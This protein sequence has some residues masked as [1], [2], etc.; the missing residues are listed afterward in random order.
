M[1]GDLIGVVLLYAVGLGSENRRRRSLVDCIGGVSV[2][3]EIPLGLWLRI[4]GIR[5]NVR[6]AFRCFDFCWSTFPSLVLWPTFSFSSTDGNSRWPACEIESGRSSPKETNDFVSVA[7]TPSSSTFRPC[8]CQPGIIILPPI[9]LCDSPPASV[10]TAENEQDELLILRFPLVAMLAAFWVLELLI[11]FS[12]LELS[13]LKLLV[14][15]LSRASRVSVSRL[16]SIR[17]LTVTQSIVAARWIV[18]KVPSL[19]A[20]RLAICKWARSLDSQ[21]AQTVTGAVHESA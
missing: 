12:W 7:S 17:F 5:R 20:I 21:P 11:S 10:S 1:H 15:L 8:T 2:W 4:S 13:L 16:V 18:G 6:D 3:R 9:L 19:S 14:W